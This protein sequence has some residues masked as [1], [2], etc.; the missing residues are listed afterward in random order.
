MTLCFEAP[1]A[2]SVAGRTLAPWPPAT[3]VSAL[4]VC[5]KHTFQIC[6]IRRTQKAA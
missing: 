6:D 2:A 5:P 3:P 4:R 1:S